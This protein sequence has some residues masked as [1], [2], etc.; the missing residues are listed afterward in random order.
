MASLNNESSALYD[1]LEIEAARRMKTLQISDLATGENDCPVLKHQKGARVR[2]FAKVAGQLAENYSKT[3]DQKHRLEACKQLDAMYEMSQ[4]KDYKLFDVA[5]YDVAYA[6]YVDAKRPRSNALRT[7]RGFYP[8]VALTGE[9]VPAGSSPDDHDEIETFEAYHLHVWVKNYINTTASTEVPDNDQI[10]VPND[11]TADEQVVMAEN[12]SFCQ[13]LKEPQRSRILNLAD[14]QVYARAGRITE[15]AQQAG[16]CV[17]RFGLQDGWDFSQSSHRRAL[18]RKAAQEEP[19]EIFISPR[20]I[21]WSPM[22][23][24]NVKDENDAQMLQEQRELDYDTHLM[25]CRIPGTS[26]SRC[27][28]AEDYCT[29]LAQHFA[30]GMMAEETLDDQVSAADGADA[31]QA[32]V[33]RQLAADHGDGPARAVQA[34]TLW[35]ENGKKTGAVLSMLDESTRFMAGRVIH[36]EKGENFISAVERAWIRNYGPLCILKVDRAPGWGGDDVTSWAERH[37]NEVQI[38]PGQAW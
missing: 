23:N 19:N 18:I 1:E 6:A 17:E 14:Q 3:F 4:L 10:P 29:T 11:S 20:C 13:E 12:F 38:S 25:M 36:D 21:L 22:Q 35:I 7:A 31:E 2:D 26:I 24:I 16:A 30:H 9:Q 15:L 5:E 28:A 8:V 32:G 33:L 27:R 37:S 34:D